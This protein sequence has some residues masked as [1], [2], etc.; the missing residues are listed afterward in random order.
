MH[1]EVA[2]L[3]ARI[4]QQEEDAGAVSAADAYLM[5]ENASSVERKA[6]TG[7]LHRDRVRE[8][9][10]SRHTILVNILV[11]CLCVVG[12]WNIMQLSQYVYV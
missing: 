9:E 10:I 8:T 3:Q 7:L 1:D 2:R 6:L 5:D 11:L 4:K 12:Q